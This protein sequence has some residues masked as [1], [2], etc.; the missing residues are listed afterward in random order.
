ME[1]FPHILG[2]GGAETVI[3]YTILSGIFQILAAFF[4]AKAG[5]KKNDQ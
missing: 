2:M 3:I 4:G 5:T 1:N